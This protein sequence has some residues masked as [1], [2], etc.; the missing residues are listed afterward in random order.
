[1][2]RPVR[3]GGVPAAGSEMT[4]KIWQ[5]F[6]CN[7]SGGY[8]LIARFVDA[9]AAREAAVEMTEFFKAHAA[10]H[11]DDING[12][13]SVMQ[14]LAR[15][16]GFDWEDEGWGGT[17]DGPHVVVEDE[18][19]FVYHTYCLGLGPGVAAMVAER[20]GKVGE[21]SWLWV[22]MSVLFRSEPSIDPRLDEALAALFAQPRDT[23]HYTVAALHLPWSAIEG[24]GRLAFF[25]DRGTIGLYFPVEPKE[26][27]VVRAWLAEHGVETASIRFEEPADE[28]LF[29]AIANARCTACT[30]PL[31]YL[32]PRLH[33]IE[34]PQ[35]VCKPCGG[36]YELSAFWTRP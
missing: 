15:K 24:R 11:G 17:E 30:G 16:Y 28:Q 19:L 27:A 35:L 20:G 1:V 29:D 5:A 33:D 14:T 31:E 2:R 34:S 26:I 4:I 22:Q 23:S 6:S 3:A 36:L 7:N 8:R 21:E 18:L 10:E 32:D 13:R 9:T 12:E 25:R